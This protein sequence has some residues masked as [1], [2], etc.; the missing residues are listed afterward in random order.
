MTQTYVRFRRKLYPVSSAAGYL[1]IDPNGNVWVS[2]F[3]PEWF[4]YHTPGDGYWCNSNAQRLIGWQCLTTI[5]PPR[6]P[7]RELYRLE[8][9]TPS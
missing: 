8:Q 4:A 1:S 5:K 3:R 6:E 2:N 9:E 7:A